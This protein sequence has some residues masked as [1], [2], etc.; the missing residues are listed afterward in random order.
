MKRIKIY[1]AVLL[2][3]F[4]VQLC[5]PHFK[6][7]ADEPAMNLPN[8]LTSAA[9]G[10]RYEQYANRY[11]N[12]ARPIVTYQ[13]SGAEA[14]DLAGCEM[15]E[16]DGKPDVVRLS[17]SG[18]ARW[19]FDIA[20]QGLY[21]IGIL[22]NSLPDSALNMNIGV[23][24]NGEEP[25]SEAE[26][27]EVPCVFKN[28]SP[29]TQ[30]NSGND[31]RP[32]QE[33][34]RKWERFDL[35]NNGGTRTGS[36]LFYMNEGSN[37]IELYSNGKGIAIA[38]VSVYN[39][40]ETQPYE[41]IVAGYRIAGYKNANAALKIQ[42]EEAEFK[43]SSMLYPVYDR[44]SAATEPQSAENIRLNMLG[45]SNW[46]V[47]G[48]WVSW[49]VDVP[50]SG[51]YKLAFKFRQ[52]YLQ[53]MFSTRSLSIDGRIPFAEADNIKF[54]YS[55]NW[56]T[57]VLGQEEPYLFY[58]EQGRHEIRL[59]NTTGDISE[60]LGL[61]E[62]VIGEM[63]DI[64]RK[65][66]MV[67]SSNPDPYR[68]YFWEK[69]IPD[70]KQILM[71]NAQTLNGQIEKIKAL[72]GSRGGQQTGTVESF[73]RQ[74]ED[75]AENPD[76]IAT[77]LKAF[78]DNITALSSWVQSMKNQAL[79][80]DY[81]EILPFE[82]TPQKPN[83]GFWKSFGF[84]M[85]K[86]L[87]SFYTDYSISGKDAITE[88]SITVWVSLGRDQAGIIK[89]LINEQFTPRTGISVNLELVQGS[90]LQATLAGVGPDVALMVG[91]AEPV[92]YAIRGALVDLAQ[93]PDYEEVAQ[94]FYPS[95]IVP[96]QFNGGVYALPY[97]QTYYMMYYRE[98]VLSQLGIEVPQT[99]DDFYKAVPILQRYYMEVGLPDVTAS[100][101]AGT[102]NAEN[103]NLFSALLFQ[104][105]GSYY[106]DDLRSSAFD[107][108]A[109]QEA[110][111][112]LSECYTRYDFPLTYDFFTRFRTGEMPLG[113]QQY[114]MYN[115]LKAAAP[116]IS[117][118]WGMAPIPG[119]LREDG[120]IDRSQGSYGSGSVI[121]KKAKNTEAAWEFLKWFSEAETQTRYGLE[122]ESLLGASGRH[123]SANVE[124][125]EGLPWSTKE[126]EVLK[127]QWEQVKGIPE[128]PGSYYTAMGLQNAFRSA[129]VQRVNP[130]E[131]L[132]T[133]NRTINEE[134]ARKYEEFGIK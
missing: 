31:V 106:K 117:G 72:A 47:Q 16:Y 21:R 38:E 126:L 62:N 42:G 113:I 104:R 59:T 13:K 93:F 50:E 119:T 17:A 108:V 58:L 134:I 107:E 91:G 51:L 116:E 112:E 9:A 64:Y 65:V 77:R 79:D 132:N 36:F 76:S 4:V 83:A 49:T 41:E 43:S 74:I 68:D 29:I 52:S 122:L 87:S 99:W 54:P 95:A 15:G 12:E 75:I 71:R 3:A 82:Q 8:I 66:I 101:S 105:G 35:T 130:Y 60:T 56:S 69:Q 2:S 20:Q 111:A 88:D 120:S 78:S 7:A 25:F 86:F 63:N 133:W 26:T 37:S 129:I 61:F 128:L 40:A 110:F 118:L 23:Q 85:K 39:A 18:R 19:Q 80:I 30:D 81:I 1:T 114:A 5:L 90:V 109:A 67:A 24:V 92:N 6:I 100:V 11:E 14:Q 125:V 96:Y 102:G 34:V 53:G 48:Q 27:M 32:K 121:F 131:A 73:A 55:E 10:N 44:T 103:H 28:A 84:E 46:N 33:K 124:A 70:F 22:Y 94:R 98:D 123:A 89:D 45:G 57:L 127:R 115:Q 97:T